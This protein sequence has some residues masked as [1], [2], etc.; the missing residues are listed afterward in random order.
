MAE[1]IGVQKYER[2]HVDWWGIKIQGREGRNGK[3]DGGGGC[4][5]RIRQVMIEATWRGGGKPHK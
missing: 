2:A 1:A 4:C 3:M 5:G